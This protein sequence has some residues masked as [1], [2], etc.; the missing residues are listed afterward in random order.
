MRELKN[1]LKE[2]RMAKY[3]KSS[4]EFAEFLG[5]SVQKYSNW[6]LGYNAPKIKAALEIAEKLNMKI[7]E[8]WYLE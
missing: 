3:L 6:E 5:V 2:I 8:I 4:S 1:R 7:E